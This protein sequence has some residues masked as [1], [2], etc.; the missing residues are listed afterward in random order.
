MSQIEWEELNFSKFIFYGAIASSSL[1]F[2][3]FPADVIKTRMQIQM[4]RVSIISKKLDV[5]VF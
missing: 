1:Q 4:A 2:F 5:D 3:S